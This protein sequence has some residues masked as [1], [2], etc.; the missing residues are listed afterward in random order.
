MMVR[1]GTR[2]GGGGVP[3]LSLET[4]WFKRICG[5]RIVTFNIG[6]RDENFSLFLPWSL[7]TL[8]S[9]NPEKFSTFQD[10]REAFPASWHLFLIQETVLI[11]LNLREHTVFARVYY[12]FFVYN[13]ASKKSGWIY[14]DIHK[15]IKLTSAVENLGVRCTRRRTTHGE[16]WNSKQPT[17]AQRCRSETEKII[18]ED[19]FSS[20]LL[21]FKNYH[22]SGNLTLII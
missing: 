6:A 13:V 8:H 20:V 18:L 5:K 10:F 19:F 17:T 9:K 21:R 1:G 3:W 14:S 7:K 16:I 22:P 2:S 4:P 11:C 15:H 12:V